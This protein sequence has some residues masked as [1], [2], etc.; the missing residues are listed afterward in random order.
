MMIHFYF[1]ENIYC[2]QS[3]VLVCPMSAL[4][5]HLIL[6]SEISPPFFISFSVSV[7]L[8]FILQAW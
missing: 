7:F 8:L 1:L 5:L 4:N 6:G 2:K 3:L